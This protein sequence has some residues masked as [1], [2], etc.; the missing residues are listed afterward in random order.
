[1][2][3]SNLKLDWLDYPETQMLVRKFAAPLYFRG[4]TVRDSVLGIPPR[5]IDL[6]V[7]VSRKEVVEFLEAERF[8]IFPG[9]DKA[10][11]V[12]GRRNNIEYDI[13]CAVSDPVGSAARIAKTGGAVP[14]DFTINS[15]Y[16]SPGGELFDYYR[17]RDDLKDGRIR[18]TVDAARQIKDA[19]VRIIRFFRF[20]AEYGKGDPD[21]VTVAFCAELA[22]HI[23]EVPPP[24]IDKHMFYFLRVK[25]VSG[26]LELMRHQGILQHIFGF[27]IHTCDLVAKLEQV[28]NLSGA[29]PDAHVRL[30]AL[31]L[32]ADRDPLM[33]LSHIRSAWRMDDGS[34]QWKYKL[35]TALPSMELLLPDAT[36]KSLMGALGHTAFKQ[37]VL[38][39]WATESDPAAMQVPYQAIL[40]SA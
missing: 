12:T 18:F 15:L 27:A 14:L 7:D 26:M 39:K 16:L 1:M 35:L 38:L 33:A 11:T 24:L 25:K 30:M 20:H 2:Q 6:I 13:V 19:Y 40:Q 23:R 36:R 8:T 17:G 22:P 32:N 31:L 10:I 37:L 3:K 4:G 28:E 29:K 9:D 21:P 34:Y 5:D